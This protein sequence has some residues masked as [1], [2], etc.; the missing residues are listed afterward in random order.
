[1]N[2]YANWENKKQILNYLKKLKNENYKL[3]KSNKKIYHVEKNRDE[4][5][6]IVME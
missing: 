4:G 1:M 2:F 3:I 5:Q 6:K